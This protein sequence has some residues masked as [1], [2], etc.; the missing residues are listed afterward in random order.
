[1]IFDLLP[2]TAEGKAR[3]HVAVRRLRPLQM[4]NL[5]DGLARGMA[6]LREAAEQRN[7]AIFLLTDGE[8]N[9]EPPR[10]YLPSL[11]QFKAAAGSSFR[12]PIHTFGFGYALDSALLDELASV[13]N[14]G[15]FAFCPDG[16]FIG[17]VF[18]HALSR[19]LTTA[20]FQTEVRVQLPA[21]WAFGAVRSAASSGALAA[22]DIAG[23]D[24]ADL[25][26]GPV[27]Y[28]A[29]A[30]TLVLPVVRAGADAAGAF[31]ETDVD[32][33]LAYRCSLTGTPMSAPDVA[34][35]ADAAGAHASASSASSASSAPL[36]A[37]SSRAPSSA[38]PNQVPA[39]VENA[40]ADADPDAVMVEVVD[41]AVAP[42]AGGV[43]SGGG[44]VSGPPAD[45]AAMP[46]NDAAMPADDVGEQAQIES[47]LRQRL[48]NLVLDSCARVRQSLKPSGFSLGDATPAQHLQEVGD[49]FRAFLVD[50]Q[51][52]AAASPFVR[53]LV[54]DV[55]GQIAEAFSK[56]EWFERWGRHYLLS[57]ARAHQVQSCINFKDPGLQLYASPM[58]ARVRDYVDELFCN[59]APPVAEKSAEPS[60][61]RGQGS[62]SPVAQRSAFSMSSYSCADSGCVSGDSL[63]AMADGTTRPASAIGAGDQVM[64]TSAQGASVRT[65]VRYVL[66]TDLAPEERQQVVLYR[67]DGKQLQSPQ[68]RITA[69]HPVRVDSEPLVWQFPSTMV[70]G[71]SAEAK[72]ALDDEAVYSFA[73]VTDDDDD[74]AA[75]AAVGIRIGGVDVLS[76]GH[77][78]KE[79]AVTSHAYFGT[80]RVLADLERIDRQQSQTGVVVV[81]PACF[82]R[83]GVDGR[84]SGIRAP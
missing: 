8:P 32:V 82:Q 26:V 6:L 18:V 43:S 56:Q 66:R 9:V 75:A 13:G 1:V 71:A 39:A 64:G 68:L 34:D 53:A 40:H 79:D 69:W 37:A 10:G 60:F 41:A 50:C 52:Y 42:S 77:G 3:A 38:P 19:L 21:G 5:W 63:V 55:Q 15:S 35:V 73:T 22:G 25:L 29:T 80:A 83:G 47:H 67:V 36:P 61:G 58:F 12:A 33:R 7:A 81:T 57:L 59:L 54:A 78:L 84:V 49:R 44:G 76:L 27:A 72:P 4:T 23:A 28:G 70:A 16:G 17:T 30:R 48:V 31:A 46:A 20:A 14:N 24:R 51:P 2:M 65:R 45:D 62:G 74:D 11:Q